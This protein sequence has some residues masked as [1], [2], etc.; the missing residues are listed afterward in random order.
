MSMQDYIIRKVVQGDEVS[1]AYIQTESWKAAFKGIIPDD[2]LKKYTEI[3]P[4]ITMYQKLLDDNRGN[5][6]ILEIDG[7]P[8]C[9]AWWDATREVDMQ[10]YAEL[11]CIH[12]LQDNWRKGYG[13]KMM[14]RVLRDVKEA[15]FT[16]IMLWV[17]EE[18]KN[19]IKFYEANGFEAS[20]RKQ[21][22]M[23]AIEVMYV[24]VL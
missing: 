13:N 11:I 24:K 5:G 14:E 10:G 21:P 12:S 20:G 16:K 7:K 23:G 4:V 1:L 15:G 19:A 3:S 18:N 6:Y 22:A 8:H 17:F 2:L 9:I